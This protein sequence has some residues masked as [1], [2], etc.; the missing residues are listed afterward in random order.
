M[1]VS[2]VMK[3]CG[4]ISRK[5]QDGTGLR[6]EMVTATPNY[7]NTEKLKSVKYGKEMNW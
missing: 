7:T 5:E 1:S 6:M 4:E 3:N 2:E